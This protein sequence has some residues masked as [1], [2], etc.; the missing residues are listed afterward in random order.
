M[1]NIYDKTVRIGTVN[2]L[3][4]GDRIYNPMG[5][6]ITLSAGSKKYNR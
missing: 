4:Q 1:F 5:Q 3:G 2:K 6:A